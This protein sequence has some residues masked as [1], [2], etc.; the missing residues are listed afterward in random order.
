VANV[1]VQ[2]PHATS[3]PG[4]AR[5]EISEYLTDHGLGALDPDAQLVV[6]ELV[7]NAVLHSNGPICLRLSGTRG[8]RIEVI[9]GGPGGTQ[10]IARRVD[11]DSLTGRGLRVVSTLAQR[12]G[13]IQGPEGKTVWAELALRPV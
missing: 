9:D 6:S 10:I 8:L 2:L 1:E 5:R 12:W 13:S 3:S 4:R 11:H 7:S